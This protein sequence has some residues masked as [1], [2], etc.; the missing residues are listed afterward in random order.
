M[1][2]VDLLIAAVSVLVAVLALFLTAAVLSVHGARRHY[3]KAI[4]PAARPE[5]P[6]AAEFTDWRFPNRSGV[7]LRGFEPRFPD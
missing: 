1:P 4:A 2:L 6:A 7:P 3:E 5:I